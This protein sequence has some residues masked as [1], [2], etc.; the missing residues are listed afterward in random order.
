MSVLLLNGL[1]VLS[2]VLRFPKRGV[3][4]AEVELDLEAVALMPP[5]GTPA[6][7]AVGGVILTGTVADGGTFGN[8]AHCRVM[9]GRNGW[10]TDVPAQHFANPAGALISTLVYTATGLLVGEAVLDPIPEVFGEHFVRTAGP[11]SRVFGDKDWHVDP[12]TGIA[13]VAPWLPLPFDPLG[14]ISDY[15]IG[16]ERFSLI[17]DFLILPGTIIADPLRLGAKTFVAGD[18]EQTFDANGSHADVWT[19]EG[20]TGALQ[21][22][23]TAAVR[24]FAGV[25]YLKTYR[26][27]FVL[28]EG[29]KLALQAITPGAPDLNPVAQW[30][31]LSGISASLAGNAALA[32]A[33]EIVVGFVGGDPREPFL[34]AFSP[35][36]KPLALTLDAVGL[37]NVGIPTSPVALGVGTA[38]AVTALQ[39]EVLALTAWVA[40][41]SAALAANPVTYTPFAAAMTAPGGAVA[42]A[43]ATIGVPAVAAAQALIPSTKLFS[44]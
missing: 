22:A 4:S 10:G 33:T 35:L 13:M 42:A 30:T 32:P 6:L 27:R 12:I 39:A 9:G 19:G 41:L 3:W 29:G 5:D 18:V 37:V 15:D 28:P 43:I 23:I 1:R 11:A 20:D 36:A 17:S 38:A 21:S 24:E 40:A 26:Y 7:L 25:Q 44:Q 14:V 31:G 16:N 2:A 8:R 34:V